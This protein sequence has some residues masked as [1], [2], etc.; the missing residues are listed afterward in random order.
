MAKKKVKNKVPSKVWT[1]YKL[2]GDT[3]IKSKNCPRCGPGYFLAE[4]SDRLY[5]GKCKYVEMKSKEP[6]A[7]E[8][9]VKA[10]QP[11]KE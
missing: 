10:V 3:L 9:E 11:K 7:K 8:A 1:K 5:C 2:E 6:A 4:H